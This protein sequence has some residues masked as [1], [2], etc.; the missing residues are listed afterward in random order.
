MK[1]LRIDIIADS[2]YF[3]M[4]FYLKNRTCGFWDRQV[5]KKN[6][7]CPTK[8]AFTSYIYETICMIWYHLYNFKNLKNIHGGVILFVKLEAEACNFTKS[9]TPPW[10]FF[11]FFKLYKWYQIAQRIIYREYFAISVF[12]NRLLSF[13]CRLKIDRTL[14]ALIQTKTGSAFRTKVLL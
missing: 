13:L 9:Y 10:V 7:F 1:I 2:L 5:S 4:R 6:S 8:W 14:H 12:F 3:L 11:P